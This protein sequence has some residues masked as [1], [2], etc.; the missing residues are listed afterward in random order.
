MPISQN[1]YPG[2]C[3]FCG[4]RVPKRKGRADKTAFGWKVSHL[5][6]WDANPPPHVK[7]DEPE[8]QA[9]PPRRWPYADD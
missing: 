4:K 3:R 8:A 1:T 5:K 9:V 6:C 2:T 7:A